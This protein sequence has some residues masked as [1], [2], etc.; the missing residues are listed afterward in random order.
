MNYTE[1]SKEISYALR[2][3]PQEYGLVLD[4]NGWVGIENLLKALR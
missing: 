1:L 3:R 2:H 4:E